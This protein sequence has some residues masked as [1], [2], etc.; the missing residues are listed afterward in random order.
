[1]SLTKEV[2]DL[3]K[4]GQIRE[5]VMGHAVKEASIARNTKRMKLAAKRAAIFGAVTPGMIKAAQK[6]A[7]APPVGIG[8]RLWHVGP[9]LAA[10]VGLDALSGMV[11]NRSLARQHESSFSQMMQDNPDLAHD[12][13]MARRHFDIM[14][15]FAPDLASDPTI[16]A[17]HV[18]QVVEMG[19]II[20]S[21]TIKNLSLAQKTYNEA[22]DVGGVG[23]E[24]VR[25]LS[26][27]FGTLLKDA[28][29]IGG[30]VSAGTA[31]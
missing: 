4:K 15:K 26:S 14:K 16:A 23:S 21:D 2:L 10:A 6:P 24:I 25:G 7:P 11:R 17:G 12:P 31:G 29:L 28:P 1:V 13:V 18:R 19:N 27:G 9:I 8:S 22:S 3:Y 30:M 20:P 5:D